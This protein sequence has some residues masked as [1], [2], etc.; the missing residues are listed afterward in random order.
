MEIINRSSYMLFEGEKNRICSLIVTG[1]DY[2][3]KLK[4]NSFHSRMLEFL[5]LSGL[6]NLRNFSEISGCGYVKNRFSFL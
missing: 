4:I 2:Q 3:S 5:F 6:E 1:Y